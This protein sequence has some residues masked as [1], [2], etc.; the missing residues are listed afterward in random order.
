MSLNW[1]ADPGLMSLCTLEAEQS[2]TG[3]MC[4]CQRHISC[5]ITWTL[6]EK[7]THTH[8]HSGALKGAQTQTCTHHQ[9]NR[10]YL[11]SPFDAFSPLTAT[12]PSTVQ[13]QRQNFRRLRWSHIL[14]LS[15]KIHKDPYH[16]CF[17]DESMNASH[18]PET[19]D[20]SILLS[21]WDDFI[22]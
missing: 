14:W 19:L 5:Y 18:P 17:T 13:P 10:V 11:N 15:T 4:V 20:Y 8:I 9:T 7:L 6:E 3:C 2:W 16:C 21:T 22:K 12:T 1:T